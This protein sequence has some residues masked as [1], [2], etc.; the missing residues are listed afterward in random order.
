[1]KFMMM[2][3]HPEPSPPPPQALMDAMDKLIGDTAA[4]GS[5]VLGGGL[6]P[7]AQSHRVK[8]SRGAIKVVDGPFTEAKEV[9]GG[10]AILEFPS[11][12]E[13]LKSA[14]YFMDLHRQ[15]WP[16]WEGECEVREIVGPPESA[17]QN[18]K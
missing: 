17:A 11:K 1:M 10:F 6:A 14:E 16:G 2:V 9:I 7:T 13:A 12:A 15:H 18:K 4:S 8:L 5:F 3:K